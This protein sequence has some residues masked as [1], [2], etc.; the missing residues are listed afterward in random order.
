[1]YGVRRSP[2]AVGSGAPDGILP[3]S[4]QAPTVDTTRR[5][6]L[7]PVEVQL[8]IE[9]MT[10]ASCVNRIERFLD[11]TPGVATA[12]VNLATETATIRYLPDVA[13]RSE[14]VGAIEAAGYDVR[15]EHAGDGRRPLAA[16]ADG[17]RRGAAAREPPP[18]AFGP[19]SRSPS[20]S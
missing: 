19:S 10:C 4:M 1:M 8:P 13:G 9:G 3:G 20:R 12:T 2:G 6:G 11:R 18:A 5:A 17:S 15:P 16:D 7:A 14:L